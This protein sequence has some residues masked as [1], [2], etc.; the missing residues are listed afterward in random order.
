MLDV[1]KDKASRL[2]TT[3]CIG[4]LTQAD[5]E[6][7]IQTNWT[8]EESNFNELFIVLNVQTSIDFK[9]MLEHSIR[10]VDY[11][12]GSTISPRTAIVATEPNVRDLAAF[13]RATQS[14]KS[15]REVEL[16]ETEE[17]ARA[18]LAET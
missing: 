10:A 7:Y 3:K 4:E 17:Q 5:L 1:S 8:D 14:L 6:G 12:L 15:V 9:T 16:F 18:W 13:Y 11:N 2:I